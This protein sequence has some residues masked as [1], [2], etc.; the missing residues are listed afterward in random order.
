MAGTVRDIAE[1][2]VRF[3]RQ[4]KQALRHREIFF[5]VRS[6]DVVDLADSSAFENCENSTTIIFNVQPVALL[7]A[8]AIDWKRSVVERI[9]DHQR[10][11]FFGELVGTVVVRGPSDQSG[12]LVGANVG[13]NQKIRGRLGRGIGT[14]W[15]ER[16][17]FAG[18]SSCSDVAI[19]FI[20][21]NVNEARN[22][23]L[24]SDLE[25]G[26]GPSDIGLY[27]GSGFVNAS[28][29]VRFGSKMDDGIATAHGGFCRD[30]VANVTFNELIAGTMRNRVE[31]REIAS[32][33]EFVVVDDRVAIFCVQNIA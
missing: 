3:A 18:M 8:V 20:G 29:D 5:H 13:A 32:V 7:F 9:R 28:V 23:K 10:Q 24:A 25:E 27:Y 22:G 2:A 17:V 26:E 1:Q 33:G 11:E 19:D 15:L 30:G 6:P 21:G 16:R 4:T 14:A 31:V 12:K